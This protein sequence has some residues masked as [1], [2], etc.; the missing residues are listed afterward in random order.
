MSSTTSAWR[1]SSRKPTL[2]NPITGCDWPSDA[3][4]ASCAFCSARTWCRRL[5]RSRGRNG[6]SAAALNTQETSGRF[7]AAQSSPAKMP[8]RGPG[9]SA[10]ESG[11]TGRPKP[12]NRV[13]S[14]LAFRI[15]P[16]HCGFSRAMTRARIV[17][18]PIVRIGLS[19][20]P[21]RRP[22][23]PASS[24]P[25]VAGASLDVAGYSLVTVGALAL[26]TRG[27]FLDVGEVLI[28]N[29]ALLARERDEA[30]S[31]GAADQRQS[32]LPRQVDAPCRKARARNQDR[33]SHPH[34]LD[35]HLGGQPSGG[36]EDLVG[37]IDVVAEHP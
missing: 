23:P 11:I 22:R 35:H 2:H 15:N 12:A 20:P 25:G 9:K 19:P 4:T 21:I 14:P 36:V 7:A 31:A 8:A 26:V 6:Q 3:A 28:V 30:L 13:G 34:R 18:P 27:F 37:G 16:S 29:D 33:D 24:I 10:T 5:T 32:D 17:R 1:S